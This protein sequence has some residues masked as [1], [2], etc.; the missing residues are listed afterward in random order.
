MICPRFHEK[1]SKERKEQLY[2]Y[3][4]GLDI[5]PSKKVIVEIGPGRGDF[6]WHLSKSNPDAIVVAV[7]IKGKR[8]AKLITRSQQRKLDNIVI[9]QG[10]AKQ[11][12]PAF[13]PLESISELHVNFPDPWP[14]T[15]H[16]SNRLLQRDFLLSCIERLKKEGEFFFA[17]DY[18]DYAKSVAKLVSTLPAFKTYYEERI[19]QEAEHAFPTFFFEKWKQMGRSFYYQRYRKV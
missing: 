3:P 8:S 10:N 4:A 1:T 17:T 14:K 18:E 2:C 16:R 9:V 13:F 6:L 15:K 5:S 7:E 19:V 11:A 12:L